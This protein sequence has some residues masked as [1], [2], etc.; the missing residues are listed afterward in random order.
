VLGDFQQTPLRFGVF[1]SPFH[2]PGYSAV[3]A[4]A[5]TIE[6]AETL[7]RLGFDELW[8][9]EHHSAGW[10]LIASPEIF[11]SHLAARTRR[12]R[13]GTGVASLPYHH[14]FTI[15]ER[16]VLLDV[17]SGG[18]AMFGVGPGN[19]SYDALMLGIDTDVTRT[20][21]GEALGVI[22][23]LLLDDEPVDHEG[24]WFTLR[25]AKLQLRPVQRP[26]IPIS[27]AATVSPAGPRT[28]GTH[29]VG[30][31]SLSQYLPNKDMSTADQWVIASEAAALAGK[32]I[33]RRNWT[34]VMPMHIAETRQQA[35]DDMREG[36]DAWLNGFYRATMGYPP[37]FADADGV[38]R[39][40]IMAEQGSA[41][42]GT[43][44]DA[45]EL[46]AALFDDTGGFGSILIL[47]TNSAP[48]PQRDHSYELF[49]RHV[50]PAFQG[51]AALSQVANDRY[52]K[53]RDEMYARKVQAQT[54]AAEEW[55]RVRQGGA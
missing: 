24:E 14:P 43:P 11:L 31:L 23:R 36:G 25:N 29:G 17:L 49:A 8:V 15:S 32:E 30:M 9:G 13:L 37:L 33:D 26:T 41:L 55:E 21:L 27:V 46:I 38:S 28:A 22:L 20:R 42:I 16:M 6:L 44:D 52:A 4:I 3:R 1:A 50:F 34:L 2:P 39:I 10:E 7:D 47:E 12:I 48:I 45:I 5:E 19:L 40:E 51:T 53:A 18:R 35:L 54:K